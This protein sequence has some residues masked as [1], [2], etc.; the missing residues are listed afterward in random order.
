MNEWLEDYMLLT[1]TD[2]LSSE[3][4]SSTPDKLPNLPT[5]PPHHLH[6][7][8]PAKL[9]HL[10]GE[11]DSGQ[12]LEAEGMQTFLKTMN[13]AEPFLV[14]PSLVASLGELLGLGKEWATSGTP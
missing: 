8:F 7:H 2:L 11:V 13:W 6:L 1:P 14:F 4:L 10:A 9:S 12:G 5:G 3:K